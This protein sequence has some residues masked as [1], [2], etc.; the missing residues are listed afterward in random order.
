VTDGRLG[1]KNQRGFY[2]YTKKK[3]RGK[4][5]VDA[6]VYSVL[7]VEPRASETPTTIVQR[8][9]LQ[10]VNEAARCYGEGIV[11]TARDGDIGAIFGLGFPPFRGGPFRYIDA[12]S[13]EQIV[14]RLERYQKEHGERFTPAPILVEMAKRGQRFYGEGTVA[15][16]PAPRAQGAV[17]PTG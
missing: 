10:M 17:A 3:R 11:K 5:P 2:S 9:A 16:V 12:V 6:S 15:S 13:T 1:R 4:K 8:C 7:G 14:R